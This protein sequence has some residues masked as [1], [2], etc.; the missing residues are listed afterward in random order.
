MAFSPA[1]RRPLLGVV[2]LVILLGG[3]N[4]A[5]DRLGTYRSLPAEPEVVTAAELSAREEPCF[6]VLT[7][8][9]FRPTDPPIRAAEG[10]DVPIVD[11]S[12]R[13]VALAL[14]PFGAADGVLTRAP[15]GVAAPIAASTRYLERVA[16]DGVDVRGVPGLMH[17]RAERDPWYYAFE[18]V[19]AAGLGL[20]FGA[21]LIV[22]GFVTRS[23]A[24]AL[25]RRLERVKLTDTQAARLVGV[26]FLGLA[27]V[28]VLLVCFGEPGPAPTRYLKEA[29]LAV[30]GWV[31][32][33]L[34]VAPG[35]RLWPRGVPS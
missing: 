24:E 4:G 2:G 35:T 22:I 26:V 27:A 23:L 3:A 1:L 32:A 8:A 15:Y 17:L 31:G 10:F 18:A 33:Y 12:G 29:V 14:V 20:V 13:V 28:G 21:P 9:R 30:G 34:I 7:D 19:C 25:F 16:R 6:V 5:R 11:A